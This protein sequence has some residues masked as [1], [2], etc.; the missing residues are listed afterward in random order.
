MWVRSIWI[1]LLLW[2]IS[3]YCSI[4]NVGSEDDLLVVLHSL[5]ILLIWFVSTVL[6][7]R[8]RQSSL[9]NPWW[10]NMPT[11]LPVHHRP[12]ALLDTALSTCKTQRQL[13][14]ELRW[15]T[16]R[17]TSPWGSSG[18]VPSRRYR[19][20][21]PAQNRTP[22]QYHC[23]NPP[24]M[25]FTLLC[26]TQPRSLQTN[27]STLQWR[28]QPCSSSPCSKLRDNRSGAVTVPARS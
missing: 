12:A 6:L 8:V 23:R 16:C 17:Q 2:D 1:L 14:P 28:W 21:S 24:L 15:P 11:N 25:D 26:L 22:G 13:L 7:K 10:Q 5:A 19:L 27:S 9:F 4:R 3:T 18:S 20:H